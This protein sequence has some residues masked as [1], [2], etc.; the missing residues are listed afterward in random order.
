MQQIPSNQNSMHEQRNLLA[1]NFCR[2]TLQVKQRLRLLLEQYMLC[3]YQACSA[4][5]VVLSAVHTLAHVGASRWPDCSSCSL[6]KSIT[7]EAGI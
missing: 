2:A 6:L 1:V 4:Q 7:L 3:V 5:F